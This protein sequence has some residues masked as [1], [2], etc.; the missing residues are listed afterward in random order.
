MSLGNSWL[1]V[2]T[3][4]ILSIPVH[5]I[6][7]F[8]TFNRQEP[9]LERRAPEECDNL[10]HCR[11]IFSI[12][13]SSL[14]VTIA[15]VWTSMH[16]NVPD[17]SKVGW[18]AQRIELTVYGLVAPELVAARAFSERVDVNATIIPGR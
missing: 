16:P 10:F 12:I 4:L 17:P 7:L 11:T 8:L 15:C 5:G 18:F 1:L 2:S 9:P 14:T 6:P 13:W 3:L